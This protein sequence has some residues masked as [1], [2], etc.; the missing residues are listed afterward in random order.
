MQAIPRHKKIRASVCT[1]S[2][3]ACREF[4]R[5]VSP[6][7]GQTQAFVPNEQSLVIRPATPADAEVCGRIC[8]E[9]FTTLSKHHNFPQEFPVPEVPISI[10]SMLFSH[11]AFFCLVAER[12]GK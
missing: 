11:P 5:E 7:A 3:P 6:M 12:D 9:A 2:P 10:L 8:F 4:R 1:Q